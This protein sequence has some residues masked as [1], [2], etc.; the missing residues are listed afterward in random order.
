MRL[1]AERTPAIASL[2]ARIA[3][4]LTRLDTAEEGIKRLGKILHDR[5]QDVAMHILRPRVYRLAFLHPPQ[6]VVRAHRLAP[7]LV[8]RLA[9]G[10]AVVGEKA[11]GFQDCSKPPRLGAGGVQA[12]QKGFALHR[13]QWYIYPITF[14]SI[15]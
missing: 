7:L 12:L 1:E 4:R 2:N 13:A 14:T 11:A 5:L 6:L 8:G 10:K 3:W 9:L 15:A